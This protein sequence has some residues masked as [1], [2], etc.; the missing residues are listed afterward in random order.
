MVRKM[1][2]IHNLVALDF[3]SLLCQNSDCRHCSPSDVQNCNQW[4]HKL[5]ELTYYTNEILTPMVAENVWTHNLVI[6]WR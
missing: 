1:D 4:L 2:W 3:L 6:L 5:A